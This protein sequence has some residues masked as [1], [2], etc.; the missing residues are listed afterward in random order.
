LISI[1]RFMPAI[2]SVRPLPSPNRQIGGRAA[3]HVGQDDHA[4]PVIARATAST[5]S[6]APL[7]HIVVGADTDTVSKLSEDRRHVPRHVET[8]QPVDRA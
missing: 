5:M 8:L 4:M 7:I 3:E 1:G 2:T 6:L